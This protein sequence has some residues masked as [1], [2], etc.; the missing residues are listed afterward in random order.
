[1]TAP[2]FW[3][4]VY[5]I[6]NPRRLRRIAALMER[7]GVRVQKSVFECW[8]DDHALDELARR[9]APLLDPKN[10]S[11]RWYPLCADCRKTAA[12]QTQVELEPPG[13][14]YIA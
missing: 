13:Q 2:R 14:Y 1:M 5:D 4:I 7:F 11:V 8:L 9:I 6:A 12:R 3:V 10:D